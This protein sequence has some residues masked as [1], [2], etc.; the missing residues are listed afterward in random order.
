MTLSLAEFQSGLGRALMGEDTCP[1]DPTSA[2][3]RFT[4]AVRRSWCEG[5]TK[6][7]ARA[8]LTLVPDAERR[9]LVAEYVDRGGGLAMFLP[10]ENAAFLAFLAPRLPDPS[11]ALS[12][13]RMDQALT[14]ARLGSETF[15]LP[16]NQKIRERIE[17]RVRGRIE[18]EIRG[19][20][21]R[22]VWACVERAVQGSAE[23][24]VWEGREPE[25]RGCIEP[26]VPG[27]IEPEVRARAKPEV[28]NRPEPDARCRIERA[29]WDCIE[30][31]VRVRIERGADAALVWFHADPDSVLRA[32]YGAPSPPVGDP[33]FPLLFGPGLSN[34]YRAATA[35]EAALWARLPADDAPPALIER[36][37]ADGLVA[38]TD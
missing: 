1:V 30:C 16:E 37:I 19:R 4:A 18:R 22:E 13:C 6:I 7:A 2:G 14:R 27:S 10:T 36:L 28:Q 33:R 38:Y 24:D 8:V 26:E 34:L 23:R 9:R 35:A 25:D 5:R 20:V 31:P 3:F 15:S 11:H 17:H 29:A 21:E 32:L 12:L